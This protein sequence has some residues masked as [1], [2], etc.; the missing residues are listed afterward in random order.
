MRRTVEIVGQVE[1]LFGTLDEN[2]KLFESALHVSTYL[3]DNR[4]VVEGDAPQV[5]RA[6]RILDQYNDL[7]REGR[8]LDNG[9]VKALLR[10]ATEDHGTTLRSILEPGHPSKPRVFGKKSVTPKSS[11]QRR[12]IED[13]ERHDMVFAIGPGGTGKTYLAVA[14]AVSA[15]LG[16]QV[17]RIILARP[18]VEAGE[19]LGFLP[20]T[21]QQKI[22]PYMRPLYDALY[23][24]LDADKLERFIDKGII[25]VAPLAFM[26][27]RTLNDSFV[28]LDEAQNT[29][30]EQMKM[31]LTRL[32]FNSK[33][34]ITGDI[35]QTDLPAGRRSGLVEAIEVV[36]RIEGIAFV[37]FNERDV[38]RHNLV[39]QIIKAYDEFAATPAGRPTPGGPVP[40]RLLSAAQQ[41]A[42]M[43]ATKRRNSP[44]A[45]VMI[46]NRQR[47]IALAVRPLSD[48]LRRAQQELGF[49]EN[50]VTVRLISDSAMARL[51]RR[52]RG[53]SGP[54]DVLSF[55]ANSAP[56]RRSFPVRFKPK[57]RRAASAGDG[58]RGE[59]ASRVARTRICRRHRLVAGDGP[60]QRP[61]VFAQPAGRVA[62]PGAAR[63]DS[64]GRFRSRKRSRPDG[65]TR[66]SP[67]AA[68]RPR[69]FMTGVGMI[70]VGHFFGVAVLCVILTLFAYLNRIYR[71][72]GRV[73]VVRLRKNV[74]IL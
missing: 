70:S 73:T 34:V 5:D 53:K 39:Q 9:A 52:F 36:G 41:T 23:D 62:H 61:F 35:T 10:V 48:F 13:I 45:P 26:R 44:R 66:A 50:A 65:E 16:K 15:L 67:A 21:L 29:T 30:S 3:D 60:S 46:A 20:G 42:P 19:R 11:N 33:A 7:V 68:A 4:L 14:M 40:R 64:L 27:G 12:Y 59:E 18:A 57:R 54:T 1:N 38:V 49:P 8:R 51:N 17:N 63:T 22:D 72:L 47:R 31:F 28:I 25:E 74:E 37:H 56:T 24:L 69:T 55:P 71:E 32:G 2:L 6:I 58:G 43:A